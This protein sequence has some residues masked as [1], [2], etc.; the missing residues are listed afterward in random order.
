MP[1]G[2]KSGSR[3]PSESLQDL[4]KGHFGPKRALLGLL[5]AKRGLIPGQSVW[6]T[7]IPSQA[8]QSAAV[9]TKSGPRGPSKSIQ[10]PQKR[11]V[12]AKQALLKPLGAKK[13]GPYQAKVCGNYD[14]NPVRPICGNWDQ[15]WPQL[16]PLELFSQLRPVLGQKGPL[17]PPAIT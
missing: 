17:G 2:T 12:G 5:G 14:F 7:M 10:D 11:H 3:G 1:V 16:W 8:D 9:G 15:I 13:K 4:Q 6:G